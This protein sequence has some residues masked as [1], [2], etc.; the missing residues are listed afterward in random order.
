[1]HII[2]IINEIL[3]SYVMIAMLLLWALYFTLATG[4]VQFRMIGEMCRLLVQGAQPDEMSKADDDSVKAHK[5][6]HVSS[7]Q[8][9]AV[10]IA[11]RVGTGNLA[12]VATAI[13]LGGAGAVMWMWI[14]ALLGSANAFVESTLAQLFKVP[15]E[16]SFRGGPAYYIQ[17]GIG[18]RWWAVLFAVLITITFGL[19]FNS[20]Q[21]NTISESL[22]AF[23]VDSTLTGVVLMVMTLLV[24]C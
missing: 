17:N 19:A 11:S 6:K 5:K 3:W 10:S 8:A 16:D 24:I 12:G 7:F 14:I 22:K 21:S 23:Q 9:F 18:K 1:M 2:D 13:S 15:G 20:V 4:C